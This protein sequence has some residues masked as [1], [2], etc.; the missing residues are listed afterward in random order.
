MTLGVLSRLQYHYGSG[1]VTADEKVY[2]RDGTPRLLQVMPHTPKPLP[3]ALAEEHQALLAAE[4]DCL[5]VCPLLLPHT[6]NHQCL[7]LPID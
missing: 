7:L 4:R 5:Q 1:R 3:S 2:H 6:A